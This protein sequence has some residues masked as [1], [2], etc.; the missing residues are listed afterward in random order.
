MNTTHTKIGQIVKN[1]GASIDAHCWVEH[2][3]EIIDYSDEKLAGVSMYGTLSVVR[4]E[5]EVEIKIKLLPHIKKIYESKNPWTPQCISDSMPGYCVLK[6]MNYWKKHKEDGAKLKFGSLGFV[7]K[8]GKD[9][10]WEY[11]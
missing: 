11:G 10:F 3:G 6:S 7:Q 4:K 2:N 9:I 1:G 8:N 5:F